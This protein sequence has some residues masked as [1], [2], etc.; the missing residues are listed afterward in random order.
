M[1]ERVDVPAVGGPVDGR[2]LLVSVDEDGVPPEIIDQNW[3]WVEYGGDLLD[4]DVVGVY[5]L[6]PVAGAGPPWVY[7]WVPAAPG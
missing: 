2:N 7:V 1:W 5:E 3:L 6:E 4:A